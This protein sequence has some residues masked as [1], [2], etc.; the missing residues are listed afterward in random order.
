MP[1]LQNEKDSNFHPS[2]YE[3]DLSPQIK[4]TTN[5]GYLPKLIFP[6]FKGF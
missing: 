4:K 2:G 6:F 1:L 3:T 5:V